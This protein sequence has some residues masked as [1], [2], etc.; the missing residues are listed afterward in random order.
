MIRQLRKSL[1][2]IIPA[3]DSADITSNPSIITI[4]QTARIQLSCCTPRAKARE[5]ERSEGGRT[6]EGER[7]GKKGK[8]ATGANEID[9]YRVTHY[10]ERCWT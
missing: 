3:K 4:Y 1:L 8:P 2:S 7:K 10:A 6:N 9:K 5:K